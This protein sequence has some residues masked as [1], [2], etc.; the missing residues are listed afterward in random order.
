MDQFSGA[1]HGRIVK[2]MDLH[3]L[4]GSDLGEVIEEVIR[5]AKFYKTGSRRQHG[6]ADLLKRLGTP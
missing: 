4:A 3:N 6:S 5:R 2:E 1:D